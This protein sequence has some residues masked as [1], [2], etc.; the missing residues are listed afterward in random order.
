MADVQSCRVTAFAQGRFHIWDRF[1]LSPCYLRASGHLGRRACSG[2]EHTIIP[3][4][5]GV[6]TAVNRTRCGVVMSPTTRDEV[7]RRRSP[8]RFV[9]PIMIGC[10]RYSDIIPAA[11]KPCNL[12]LLHSSKV[13]DG[14]CRGTA[15]RRHCRRINDA[16][17]SFLSV[18]PVRLG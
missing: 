5:I 9:D 15:N 14:R 8:Q 3:Q 2:G 18:R 12:L 17:T 16:T 13:Q 6:V 11:V 1:M 7:F 4:V 10:P